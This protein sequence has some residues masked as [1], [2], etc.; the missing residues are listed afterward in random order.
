MNGKYLVISDFTREITPEKKWI[1]VINTIEGFIYPKEE[2]M[3]KCKI[4]IVPEHLKEWSQKYISPIEIFIS[5]TPERIIGIYNNFLPIER[6]TRLIK[7]HTLR[8]FIARNIDST[9]FFEDSQGVYAIYRG[10]KREGEEEI[11]TSEHLVRPKERKNISCNLPIENRFESFEFGGT[12][13]LNSLFDKIYVIHRKDNRA[14]FFESVDILNQ[15]KIDYTLFEA[16]Y[17]KIEK[18]KRDIWKELKYCFETDKWFR[19]ININNEYTIGA[20]GCTLSHIEVI[21]HAKMNGYGKVLVLEDDFLLIKDYGKYINQFRDYIPEGDVIL[22]GKK[23]GPSRREFINRYF[24]KMNKCSW[25]THAVCYTYPY[26]VLNKVTELTY[27]IDCSIIESRNELKNYVLDID[28]FIQ[29]EEASDIRSKE[30][31]KEESKIWRWNSNNYMTTNK[32]LKVNHNDEWKNVQRHGWSWVMNNVYHSLHSDQGIKL[33]DF[34]DREFGWENK[35]SISRGIIP[36]REKWIG[37]F[38]HVPS[39]PEFWGKDV[40]LEEYMRKKCW[41]DSLNTCKAIIV[42]SKYLKDYISKNFLFERSVPIFVIYHPMDRIKEKW[43]FDFNAFIENRDKKLLSIGWSYRNLTTIELVNS[44]L[45]KVWLFQENKRALQIFEEELKYKNIKL[46]ERTVEFSNF[47][48][49]TNYDYLLSRNIVFL[50]LFDASANNTVLECI[51]R[52]T[53]LI[54]NKL[55]AVVEYLGEDYPLYWETLEDVERFTTDLIYLQR[56]NEYL[57]QLDKSRF[58]IERFTQELR[59]IFEIIQ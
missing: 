3:K 28:L 36:V 35:K 57:S 12:N 43:H 41:I 48:D 52:N 23:Q 29:T 39:L 44:P 6:K 24:Y 49:N 21:R 8:P 42:L 19:D 16:I 38:H 10:A 40:C 31:L 7:H 11:R 26:R 37:I 9:I 30:R 32:Y 4:V 47:V 13:I 59:N 15:E 56:A 18:D 33:F 27:P 46:T 45:K 1:G 25:A 58:T 17:P 5:S 50:D 55:P 54:V 51:F 22:F 2:V 14:R 34:G 53:P 20:F